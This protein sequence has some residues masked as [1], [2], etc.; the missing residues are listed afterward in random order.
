MHRCTDLRHASQC[1]STHP[2]GVP[3]SFRSLQG[4][5]RRPGCSQLGSAGARRPARTR[6]QPPRHPRGRMASCQA[7]PQQQRGHCRGCGHSQSC[8][9]PCAQAAAASPGRQRDTGLQARPDASREAAA[10]VTCGV[11]DEGGCCAGAC[12]QLLGASI[13]RN[14]QG[15]RTGHLS[16]RQLI[17]EHQRGGCCA[18]AAGNGV[19]SI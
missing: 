13:S 11:L 5:W 7:P 1:M 4:Q 15:S 17:P 19:A 12:V 18:L 6:A 3:H 14:A 16:Q 8:R 2:E 10:G 9:G